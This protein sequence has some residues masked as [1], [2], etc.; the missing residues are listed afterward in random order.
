MVIF[1]DCC[2]FGCFVFNIVEPQ[3]ININRSPGQFDTTGT[4]NGICFVESIIDICD[5]VC[6]VS[7]VL[8]SI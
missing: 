6:G 2:Y 7:V 5:F 1:C 4:V 8:Y 3:S